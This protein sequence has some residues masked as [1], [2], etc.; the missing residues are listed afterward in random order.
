MAFRCRPAKGLELV[1]SDGLKA[2]FGH[3]LEALQ[4]RS[5]YPFSLGLVV[6]LQ[7][8]HSL[9]VQGVVRHEHLAQ[10]SFHDHSLSP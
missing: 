5:N 10:I 3:Q 4:L 8:F 7:R 1:I 2:V 9:A 6:Q